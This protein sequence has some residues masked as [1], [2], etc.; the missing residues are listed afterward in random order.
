MQRD[1]RGYTLRL[2]VVGLCLSMFLLG[3]GASI[4]SAIEVLDSF[5]QGY[6]TIGARFQQVPTYVTPDCTY[7]V[8]IRYNFGESRPA[9]RVK[10]SLL[11]PGG[12]PYFEQDIPVSNYFGLDEVMVEVPTYVPIGATT[13]WQIGMYDIDHPIVPI[14]E[15]TAFDITAVQPIFDLSGMMSGSIANPGWDGTLSGIGCTGNEVDDCLNDLSQN[16]IGRFFDWILGGTD[17]VWDQETVLSFSGGPLHRAA[18]GRFRAWKLYKAL[19]TGDNR[20]GQKTISGVGAKE[21]MVINNATSFHLAGIGGY[22]VQG[23]H[24]VMNHPPGFGGDGKSVALGDFPLSAEMQQAGYQLANI[25]GT[26]YAVVYPGNDYGIDYGSFN[27]SDTSTYADDDP[28]GIEKRIDID[29]TVTYNSQNNTITIS[30][31]VTGT[32]SWPLWGICSVDVTGGSDGSVTYS[33]DGDDVEMEFTLV[34]TGA[35]VQCGEHPCWHGKVECN[36]GIIMEVTYPDACTSRFEF[37]VAA[38]AGA[39]AEAYI[40]AASQSYEICNSWK[41]SLGYWDY[42]ACGD[43]EVQDWLDTNFSAWTD[44][45]SYDETITYLLHNY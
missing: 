29:F 4:V 45:M 40:P 2:L 23:T 28:G 37:F 34:K 43:Q 5:S 26:P 44:T 12:A 32:A 19:D 35:A 24:K 21:K 15:K 22:T 36:I 8:P 10:V 14:Q 20:V 16:L 6:Q 38:S 9:Q 18:A 25:G 1:M 42:D 13:S 33:A 31:G 39:H 3:G 11:G 17:V 27:S 7:I 41:K 30:Y